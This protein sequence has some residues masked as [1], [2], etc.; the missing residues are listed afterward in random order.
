MKK[1]ICVLIGIASSEDHGKIHFIE[2]P[3]SRHGMHTQEHA[4]ILGMGSQQYE[5]VKLD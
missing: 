5:L 3:N 1:N 4:E 2:R